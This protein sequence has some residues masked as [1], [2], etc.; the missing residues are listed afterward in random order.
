MK[1]LKTI[2]RDFKNILAQFEDP[3]VPFLPITDRLLALAK[4]IPSVKTI[5]NEIKID[6]E[7][8]PVKDA[9]DEPDS[10]RWVLT[11]PRF[12]SPEQTP[13]YILFKTLMGLLATAYGACIVGNL[14]E[15]CTWD[16]ITCIFT[17]TI[18]YIHYGS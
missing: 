16:E 3:E 17:L 6:D 15:Q 10:E 7:W 5:T 2:T 9:Y 4:T 18:P 14:E 11:F 13:E 12:S 1:K 8:E